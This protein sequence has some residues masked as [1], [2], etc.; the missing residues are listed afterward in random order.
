MCETA[1]AR[2]RVSA[3]AGM[4]CVAPGLC[5]LTLCLSFSQGQHAGWRGVWSRTAHVEPPRNAP[6][7]N[8]FHGGR[9]EVPESAREH[10]KH[11][12]A[13]SKLALFLQTKRV[14]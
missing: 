3:A 14:L 4:L 6:R 7:H 8:L 11:V 5:S 12:P 2:E 10:L 1:R 13:D 9:V